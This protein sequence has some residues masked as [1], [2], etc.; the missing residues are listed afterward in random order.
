MLEMIVLPA[1]LITG[2]GLLAQC[3]FSARTLVQWIMSERAHKVLS[4]SLF[5]IFSVAGSILLALYGYLRQDFS[6]VLAQF[7]SYY[8]YLWNIKMKRISL[9]YTVWGILIAIPIT[10]MVALGGHAGEVMDEFFGNASLPRWLIVY[11]SVGQVLF[12]LRFIYQWWYSRKAGVS[13]LPPVFW[14]ISL[15]GAGII[16]SYGLMRLD[17]VLMLGQGFG[18]IVYIRNLIIGKRAKLED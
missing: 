11:G 17:I 15:I 14:W 12:T 3:F 5:W 18:L 8:I 10:A 7:L 16:F 13:S 4:P 2:I 9:P 1:L 6:I